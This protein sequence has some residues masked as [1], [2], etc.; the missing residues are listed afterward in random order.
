MI[1]REITERPITMAQGTNTMVGRDVALIR[2]EAEE[3]LAVRGK[4]GRV[5]ELWDGHAAERI[6][7]HLAQWLIS[8]SG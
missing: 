5:P 3:I 2:H 6:A 8:R 1:F 7:D 4:S